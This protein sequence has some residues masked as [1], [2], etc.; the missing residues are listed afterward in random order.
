MSLCRE[1]AM[2]AV[3]RVLLQQLETN[4]KRHNITVV[5]NDDGAKSQDAAEEPGQASGDL[6]AP[7]SEVRITDFEPMI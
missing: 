5:Q 3:N 2:T 4:A 6:G 1:A 7:V